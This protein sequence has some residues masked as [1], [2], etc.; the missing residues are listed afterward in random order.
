MSDGVIVAD[1][2]NHSIRKVLFMGGTITPAG[3]SGD[4]GTTDGNAADARFKSPTAL[5]ADASGNVYIADAGNFTIRRLTPAG[6]VDT[7]AGRAG[8][9]GFTQGDIGVLSAVH[10]LAVGTDGALYATMYQGVARIA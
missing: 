2:D 8:V 3:Q 6:I 4:P 10:G 1:T 7:I 5:A 9:E